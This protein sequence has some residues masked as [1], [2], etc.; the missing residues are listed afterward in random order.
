MWVLLLPHFPDK[1]CTQ[2]E[3]KQIRTGGQD[4]GQGGCMGCYVFTVEG[5]LR[6]KGIQTN[7]MCQ[8]PR[9][10]NTMSYAQLH[11]S[12]SFLPPTVFFIFILL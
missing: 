6:D 3:G 12:S 10:T 9:A 1:E 7:Q 8:E 2:K 4:W 5:G 11:H